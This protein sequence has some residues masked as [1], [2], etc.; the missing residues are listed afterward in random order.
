MNKHEAG[1]RE[2]LEAGVV[3]CT[4]MELLLVEFIHNEPGVGGTGETRCPVSYETTWPE[5]SVRDHRAVVSVLYT[6]TAT[7]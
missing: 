5:V 7:P 2:P 1:G 6:K 3:S 4:Y